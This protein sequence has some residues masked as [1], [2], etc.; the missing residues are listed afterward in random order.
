MAGLSMMNSNNPISNF[1]SFFFFFYCKRLFS[2]E[3]SLTQRN[4]IVSSSLMHF[5]PTVQLRLAVGRAIKECCVHFSAITFLAL[6]NIAAVSRLTTGMGEWNEV[7]SARAVW[8]LAGTEVTSALWRYGR[9]ATSRGCVTLGQDW[10]FGAGGHRQIR[11]CHPSTPQLFCREN[12]HGFTFTP[13]FSSSLCVT[14]FFQKRRGL[15]C[16]FVWMPAW[17]TLE[18]CSNNRVHMINQQNSASGHYILGLGN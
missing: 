4:I 1:Y 3:K 10:P 14:L 9:A 7:L 17:A 11:T 18:T 6:V 16:P 15:L 2:R 13:F 12:T 8:R 5:T